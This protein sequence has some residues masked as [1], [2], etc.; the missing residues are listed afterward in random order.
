MAGD[1]TLVYFR[2]KNYTVD[3]KS[4]NNPFTQAD[5]E[6]NHI[7]LKNISEAF[8]QDRIR[9]E[10]ASEGNEPFS[11]SRMWVIDPMDGTKEFISDSPDFCVMIGLTEGDAPILGV[12][13]HPTENTT[14]AGVV[15]EGA[16]KI[17]QVGSDK[18]RIKKMSLPRL[19][20]KPVRLV[21]SKNHRSERLL[22]LLQQY[23]TLV[24]QSMGSAGLKCMAILDNRADIYFHPTPHIKEWDTC[25]PEAIL[26]S[27]GGIVTDCRQKPL[28]YGKVDPRQTGGIIAATPGIPKDLLDAMASL[29]PGG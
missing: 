24:S 22:S 26:A 5:T 1:R 8:P 21:H 14:Y 27:V 19:A 15:G 23:P 7:I 11:T 3:E 16:W 4:V 6:A 12:I 28:T 18:Q 29:A 17:L 20:G 25:A 2:S 10:E 9:S 13:H